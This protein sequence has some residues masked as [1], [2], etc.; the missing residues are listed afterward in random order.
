MDIDIPSGS[1]IGARGLEVVE[2]GVRPTIESFAY[3]NWS[4]WSKMFGP[5]SLD[6][7]LASDCCDW[8]SIC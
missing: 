3:G 6:E 8:N 2:R 4:S 7:H 5:I 1:N